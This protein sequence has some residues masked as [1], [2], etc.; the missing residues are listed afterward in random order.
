[1]CEK[2]VKHIYK[3][4]TDYIKELERVKITQQSQQQMTMNMLGEYIG[5]LNKTY[6]IIFDVWYSYDFYAFS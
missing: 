4:E 3:S 1:M 6:T 2:F 5:K